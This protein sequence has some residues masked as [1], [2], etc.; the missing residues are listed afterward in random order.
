M[1]GLGKTVVAVA[2]ARQKIVGRK[3][4]GLVVV[5]RLAGM[6][7]GDLITNGDEE[8]IDGL[9]GPDAQLACDSSPAYVGNTGPWQT[10]QT[11]NN[12][13]NYAT[14]KVVTPPAGPAR[15]V[16]RGART[17]GASPSADPG[18]HLALIPSRRNL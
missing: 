2:A 8:P 7:F 9:E 6:S 16:T 18:N 12:C 14:V 15:A 10:Y 1:R 3:P 11:D 4:I 17:G 13:Y 5:K